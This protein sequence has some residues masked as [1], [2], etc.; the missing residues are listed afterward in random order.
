MRAVLSD[1]LFCVQN[2]LIAEYSKLKEHLAAAVHARR[3]NRLRLQQP[4][5]GELGL[6]SFLTFHSLISSLLSDLKL[7]DEGEAK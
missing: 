5:D 7:V 2:G 4:K 3:V 6:L 1:L